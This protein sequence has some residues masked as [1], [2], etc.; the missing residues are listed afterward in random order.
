MSRE[1]GYIDP[2]LTGFA[3]DYSVWTREGLI[4]G[5][6]MPRLMVSKPTG[7]YYTYTKE[8][9]YKVID[10]TFDTNG[11]AKA[12]DKFGTRQTYQ[13]QPRG[14]KQF[15]NKTER[16]K[17]EGPF[18]K[19]EAEFVEEIVGNIEINQEKRIAQKILS[20]SGRSLALTGTGSA[21]TNKWSNGG[22]NPYL[23]IRDAI[24]K[25]F[26]RPNTMII[27]EN[28]FNV[29]EDHPA[30]LAKLGEANLLKIVNEDTLAKLFRIPNVIFSL[31]K[32]DFEKQNKDKTS[33]ILSVWED[34]M[35][36]AYVDSRKDVPCVGKT[37]MVEYQESNNSGYVVRKWDEPKKG[38]LGGVEIQVAC[39]VDEHIVSDELVY[40]IQEIF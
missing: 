5:R 32:A 1:L 28:V 39:D 6:L 8:Q 34:S 36:L 37:L 3:C 21:K 4:G 26:R 35:I 22:G 9:A 25:C 29:L 20:L 31:G 16:E 40:S 23:A 18:V 27:T 7:S 38:I 11:E 10:D 2:L 30:L 15:I 13:T 17:M 19:S 33:N 24:N 12:F 14:N